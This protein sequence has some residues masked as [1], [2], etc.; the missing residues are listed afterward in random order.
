MCAV[1]FSATL[2][3]RDAERR[4]DATE[5]KKR[6]GRRDRVVRTWILGMGHPYSVASLFGVRKCQ[7]PACGA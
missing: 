4:V 6:R 7:L 5:K 1:H 3:E 2:S